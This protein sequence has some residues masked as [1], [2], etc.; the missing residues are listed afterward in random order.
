MLL[1]WEHNLDDL[2]LVEKTL[3]ELMKDIFEK[4]PIS[5][6]EKKFVQINC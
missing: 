4:T 5:D 2:R 1:G 3:G 6:E